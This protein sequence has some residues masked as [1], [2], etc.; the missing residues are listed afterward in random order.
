M[1]EDFKRRKELIERVDAYISSRKEK[2]VKGTDPA[3]H[4]ITL[5]ELELLMDDSWAYSEV[6]KVIPD[7]YKSEDG[8]WYLRLPSIKK[9]MLISK[10]GHLTGEALGY[11]GAADRWDK[12]IPR[13]EVV[14]FLSD[15]V[16]NKATSELS[17]KQ[18]KE[19]VERSANK[20][21]HKHKIKLRFRLLETKTHLG[22]TW[23]FMLYVPPDLDL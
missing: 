8:K 9:P 19:A 1:R 5:D 6:K 14:G 13:D 10:E 20:I 4:G 17:P 23:R 18:M 22:L 16:K 11:L 12:K 15:N 3:D 2:G 7:I 21:L